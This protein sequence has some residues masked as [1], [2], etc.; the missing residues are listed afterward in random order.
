M[1]LNAQVVKSGYLGTLFP[2]QTVKNKEINMYTKPNANTKPV[3]LTPSELDSV[4]GGGPDG[5][6]RIINFL[7][8][9]T[10]SGGLTEKR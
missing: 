2:N 6:L 10:A 4:A 8:G 1:L 3:E 5:I 9:E 7:I